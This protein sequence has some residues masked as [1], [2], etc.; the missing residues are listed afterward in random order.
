MILGRLGKGY[1]RKKKGVRIFDQVTLAPLRNSTAYRQCQI[2]LLKQEISN[3]K[4][5]LRTLRR[6]LTLLRNELSLTLSFVDL[7][8]VCNLF[9]IGNDKAILKHKQIQNKKLNNLRVT[10]LENFSHDTGKVIYNFSDYKLTESEKSV[11]CK[12]LEFAT[13]PNKLEYADFMLLLELLFRDI[14]NTDLSIAQTKAVKS[15]IL[16]TAFSSFDSFTK[17]KMRSNLSKE[18]LKALHNLRKQ[19]HLVIQEAGKGNTVVITEKNSYINK[20][21]EIVSN[22]TKFEQ[23]NIEEDKHLIF[24]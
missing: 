6:D 3:K 19:K 24:F 14:K 15:K 17:N 20:M 1:C 2:K 23:I 11:L 12:D 9:L 13:P 18:E 5:N 7:N 22:T 21:E 4:R 10:R 16:D 8:H